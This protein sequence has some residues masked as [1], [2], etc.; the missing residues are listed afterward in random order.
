MPLFPSSN[1]PVRLIKPENKRSNLIRNVS[2]CL[3]VDT[4]ITSQ[5]TR[6]FS[7]TADR[8]SHIG[9]SD[10]FIVIHV[11]SLKSLGPALLGQDRGMEAIG[12]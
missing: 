9:V 10:S 1:V 7:N 6:L 2:N 11:N 12:V 8:T 5:K 3:P 4:A